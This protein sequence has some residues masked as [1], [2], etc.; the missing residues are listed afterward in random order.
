SA[1]SY[2][3]TTYSA[4]MLIGL[5]GLTYSGG[6]GAL[7]FELIYLCG[8]T[9]VLV[10]GPRFWAVGQ[11]YG[12]V[13]PSEMLGHRYS[14]P[15]VAVVTALAS[16]IFLIPYAAVQLAGVGYLLSGM[17]NGAVSFTAGTVLATVLAIAFALVAGL[18]SVAWTDALQSIVMMISAT[19]VVALVVHAL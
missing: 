15:G 17:S 13:T 4:F 5:A 9:L 11:K 10:F 6:V 8:V 18:R 19:V 14:S 7:G 16:C 1:M 2:S 3:A 12:Y